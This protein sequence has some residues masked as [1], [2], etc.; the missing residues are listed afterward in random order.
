LSRAPLR[1]PGQLRCQQPCVMN[2]PLWNPAWINSRLSHKDSATCE[3]CCVVPQTEARMSPCHVD[4]H[5]QP[6][7]H[8]TG[9][10]WEMLRGTWLA[11]GLRRQGL[12]KAEHHRH[13]VCILWAW[14][15]RGFWCSFLSWRTQGLVHLWGRAANWS[16]LCRSVRVDILGHSTQRF[17]NQE[18]VKEETYS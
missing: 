1:S 14:G 7:V 18:V 12:E 17:M 13:Q 5:G 4:T 11:L 9:G 10:L 16:T 8:R 6:R 3:C 2:H 15:L